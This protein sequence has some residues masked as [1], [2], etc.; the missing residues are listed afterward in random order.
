MCVCVVARFGGQLADERNVAVAARPWRL[1][2]LAASEAESRRRRRGEWYTGTTHRHGAGGGAY[3]S[4]SSSVEC[5]RGGVGEL[6]PTRRAAGAV[7]LRAVY[8]QLLRGGGA[9]AATRVAHRRVVGASPRHG[10]NTRAA[11]SSLRTR[12][13]TCHV[14]CRERR[15]ADTMARVHNRKWRAIAQCHVTGG[16]HKCF[17]APG[18]HTR[19][20]VRRCAQK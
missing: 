10:E 1:A 19:G 12:V 16:V 20:T 9:A 14:F 13:F 17:N 15:A 4:T 11:H 5:G 7:F 3:N 2:A 18:T 6:V 8:A